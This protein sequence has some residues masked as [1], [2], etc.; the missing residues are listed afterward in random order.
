MS[1]KTQPLK[2]AS[3]PYTQIPDG[4]WICKEFNDLTAHARCIFTIA[5][6]KWNP[7][8]PD[9]AFA[10]L[11][12]D[13]REITGFQFNTISK[14]IKQLILHGFLDRP[15]RGCYPHNVALYTLDYT[16]IAKKYPK[17]QRQRPKYIRE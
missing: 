8:K 15:K 4:F 12:D 1:K 2:Y 17:K 13:L 10:M 3:S 9:D 16:W 7:Y 11:Y 6:S 5:I 14:A